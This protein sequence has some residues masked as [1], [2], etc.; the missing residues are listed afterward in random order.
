MRLIALLFLVSAFAGC[1]HDDMP[2]NLKLS[3]VMNADKQT[4]LEASE[5]GKGAPLAPRASTPQLAGYR[6]H[7]QTNYR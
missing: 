3:N 2:N 7:S 1:A 4:V 6:G 5:E